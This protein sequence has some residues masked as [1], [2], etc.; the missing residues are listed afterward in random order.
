ML[1]EMQTFK[2]HSGSL[3]KHVYRAHR[4]RSGRPRADGEYFIKGVVVSYEVLCRLAD[5]VGLRDLDI[6]I[7]G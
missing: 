5:A 3:H 7:S 4:L 1:S 2:W 6:V